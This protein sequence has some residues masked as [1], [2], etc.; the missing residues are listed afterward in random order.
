MA[1]SNTVTVD[2]TDP[3]T[4]KNIFDNV[5]TL[6]SQINATFTEV[7]TTLRTSSQIGTH[8]SLYADWK[9]LHEVNVLFLSSCLIAYIMI[10]VEAYF[11]RLQ[12]ERYPVCCFP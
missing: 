4:L 11:E 1:R 2:P 3:Q 9:G 5:L 7:E 10:G 12:R 6:Q 8:H